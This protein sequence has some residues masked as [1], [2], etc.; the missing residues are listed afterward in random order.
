MFLILLCKAV[1]WIQNWSTAVTS[2]DF[3]GMGP[4]GGWA[5]GRLFV[6]EFDPTENFHPECREDGCESY[7]DAAE[8]SDDEFDAA[9]IS[10][11][12][13]NPPKPYKDG[14]TKDGRAE[15][16]LFHLTERVFSEEE[17]ATDV[18]EIS[19]DV[20]QAHSPAER[21]TPLQGHRD[22]MKYPAHQQPKRIFTTTS[23]RLGP[24]TRLRSPLPKEIEDARAQ[25]AE[26]WCTFLGADSHPT[27][28]NTC[29]EIQLFA[30]KKRGS[31][32]QIVPFL[33]ITKVLSSPTNNEQRLQQ[34]CIPLDEIQAVSARFENQVVLY[35]KNQYITML[36]QKAWDRLKLQVLLGGKTEARGRSWAFSFRPWKNGSVHGV[37]GAAK[38]A[39]VE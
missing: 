25:I 6:P 3:N 21:S 37:V 22:R 16:H 27:A 4:E 30:R 20:P 24:R 28:R 9:S 23:P 13:H 2:S 5:H 34:M 14:R 29:E 12:V 39:S 31:P 10:T 35:R 11:P 1:V 26:K 15:E 38:H 17:R 19:E 7:A 32:T 8:R 18:V 33:D 36:Q